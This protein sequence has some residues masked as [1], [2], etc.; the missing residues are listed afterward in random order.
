MILGNA[1]QP[2]AK[3]KTKRSEKKEQKSNKVKILCVE[4]EKDDDEEEE[5]TSFWSEIHTNVNGI[6]P[7]G[8]GIAK[9]KEQKKL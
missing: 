9:D 2:K 1:I 3:W 4:E 5:E 8:P 6:P 7:N